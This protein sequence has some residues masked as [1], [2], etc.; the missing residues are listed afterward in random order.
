[1]ANLSKLVATLSPSLKKAL[2]N[3]VGEAMKRKSA[4]VETE[5]WIFHMLFGQD[6]EL[7]SFLETQGVD[8]NVLQTELDQKMLRGSG[9]DGAQ[10]T[11]S[12]SVAKLLEQS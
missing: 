3:G 12:G 1:M 4:S 10:P 8:L 9:A 6:H 5:H 7:I 11:I 2:E